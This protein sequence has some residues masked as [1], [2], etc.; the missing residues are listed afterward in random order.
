VRHWRPWEL[1]WRLEQAHEAPREVIHEVSSATART[2]LPRR[3]SPCGGGY[4][5]DAHELRRLG[6]KRVLPHG[7][8]YA[9]ERGSTTTVRLQGGTRHWHRHGCAGEHLIARTGWGQGLRTWM[10]AAVTSSLSMSLRWI[11]QAP[12]GD[13]QMVA[14]GC[15]GSRCVGLHYILLEK[16][17]D[18]NTF[19][20]I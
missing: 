14:H 5:R 2:P 18:P 10:T 12:Y 15:F 7:L 13:A 4:D 17:T 11:N 3:R 8:L 9:L 16:T 6:V 1:W 20:R 19:D